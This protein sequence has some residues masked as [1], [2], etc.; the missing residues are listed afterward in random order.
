MEKIE[1]LV[2][3]GDDS[4]HAASSPKYELNVATFSTLYEDSIVETFHN[5][6]DYDLAR[7]W[8]EKQERDFRFAIL[9]K[10]KYAHSSTNLVLVIPKII[11]LYLNELDLSPE[12]LKVYLDGRIGRGNRDYIRNYFLGK[13]GIQRVTVDNFIKKNPGPHGETIKRPHCPP[14]VYYADVLASMLLGLSGQELF[15]HKKA[16]LID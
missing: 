16:V 3:G 14:V 13:R 15:T 1:V 9:T 2:V 10:E 11:H 4:N 12:N 5:T 8:I 6:R 7:R